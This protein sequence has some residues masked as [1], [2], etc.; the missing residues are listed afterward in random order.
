VAGDPRPGLGLRL[1]RGRGRAVGV[2]PIRVE[3]RGYTPP[4]G[5]L[6]K[7]RQRGSLSNAL[8]SLYTAAEPH[9][10]TSHTPDLT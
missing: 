2:T 6:N 3:D 10:H 7:P 4:L 9:T 5:E 1:G 8:H